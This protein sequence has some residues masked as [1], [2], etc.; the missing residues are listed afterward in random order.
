MISSNQ[1]GGSGLLVVDQQ[2]LDQE[3]K[4][5]VLVQPSLSFE[6]PPAL[7]RA[8]DIAISLSM[9][10]LGGYILYGITR[11]ANKMEMVGDVTSVIH[12]LPYILMSIASTALVESASLTYDVALHVLGKRK[13]FEDLAQSENIS[14][15][16]RLRQRAWKVMGYMEK[17]QNDI[18]VIFSRLFDIRTA[19]EIRE[20][21]VVD[22]DLC[23]MEISRRVFCEQVSETA[24]NA[25]P[26]E[27][28]LYIIEA[29]GYT[30]LGG[31][32]FIW[33]H[34]LNFLNGMIDKIGKVKQ[35]VDFEQHQEELKPDAPLPGN[36]LLENGEDFQRLFSGG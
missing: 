21:G 18:D 26:Q 32:V 1:V 17:L 22:R 12:P 31:H 8:G 20:N 7:K 11:L 10:A 2:L 15:L 35:K 33:L 24:R 25:I 16:D 13:D 28:G 4:P 19:K 27:L 9:G 23:L 14:A 34:G 29:C 6:L 36:F 30:I 3:N 5:P